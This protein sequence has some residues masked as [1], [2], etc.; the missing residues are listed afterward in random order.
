ML[1]RVKTFI[2][3]LSLCM[4]T[5]TASFAAPIFSTGSFGYGLANSTTTDVTTTTVVANFG[6]VFIQSVTGDFTGFLAPL[7]TF[8]VPNPTNFSS[9]ASF[10]WPMGD[11]GSFAATSIVKG[12]VSTTGSG[13]SAQSTAIWYI[14]GLF[15]VGADYDNAGAVLG[16]IKTVSMTQ[17]GG[18][19]H[20]LSYSGTVFIPAAA[21]PEPA[22]L[23]LLGGSMAVLGF[24]RRRKTAA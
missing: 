11:V 20:A 15:T 2:W 18:A 5:A 17:T 14:N 16:A 10:T 9:L 4:M 19:G 13:S 1:T 24:R 8:A 22:T 3:A 6:E 23:L 7:D 12:A 21:V